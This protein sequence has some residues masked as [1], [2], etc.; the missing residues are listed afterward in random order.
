[1]IKKT[2][3]CIAISLI[4]LISDGFS[5]R[6][7]RSSQTSGDTSIEDLVGTWRWFTGSKVV[8]FKN[9]EFKSL[10]E[11]GTIYTGK[12][13]SIDDETYKFSWENDKWIDILQI[14]KEGN[15]LDG[16]NHA[17]DHITAAKIS[18]NTE[19]DNSEE[20]NRKSE[21]LL[22]YTDWQLVAHISNTG[23]MFDGRSNLSPTFQYGEFVSNPLPETPDFYR[24]FPFSESNTEIL[25]ITGNRKYWIKAI[26]KELLSIVNARKGEFEPNLNVQAGI[27]GRAVETMGNVLSRKEIMEDPWISIQGGHYQAA[28][29]NL[30]IW[31]ENDFSFHQTLKNNNDGVDVFIRKKNTN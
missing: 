26:Y 16:R 20:N 14:S 7:L 27:D 30:I 19:S 18:V 8:V 22:G 3:I 1:M 2:W 9:G 15:Y 24:R 6:Q 29:K 10:N 25:F 5:Q 12:C 17:G 11:N 23:G 4:G 21:N 13:T 31:G 28:S